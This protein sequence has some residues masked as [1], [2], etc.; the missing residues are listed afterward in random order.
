MSVV[1]I[2]KN[3]FQEKMQIIKNHLEINQ[4]RLSLNLKH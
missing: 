2:M 3:R 4:I 1:M